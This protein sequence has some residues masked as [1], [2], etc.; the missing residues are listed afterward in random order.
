MWHPFSA[1][2]IYIY[3]VLDVYKMKCRWIYESH[4]CSNNFKILPQLTVSVISQ[5]NGFV[6][7]YNTND[8][9]EDWR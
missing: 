8:K 5:Y 4:K 2:F 7:K 1:L 6:L 3:L 9:N